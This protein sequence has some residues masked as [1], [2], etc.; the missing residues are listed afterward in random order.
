MRAKNLILYYKAFIAR[1]ILMLDCRVSKLPD[2][3]SPTNTKGPEIIKVIVAFLSISLLLFGSTLP[4]MSYSQSNVTSQG[5]GI[6][7]QLQQQQKQQLQL[8]QPQLQQQQKQELQ[9][10]MQEKGGE[11]RTEKIPNGFEVDE[12][13]SVREVQKILNQTLPSSPLKAQILGPTALGA[14]TENQALQAATENQALQVQPSINTPAP[15]T[16]LLNPTSTQPVSDTGALAR[17]CDPGLPIKPGWVTVRPYPYDNVVAEGVIGGSRIN[18]VHHDYPFNH[19]SHDNNFH[20]ILDPKYNGLA[21]KALTPIKD[22]PYI[23]RYS[24]NQEWEIGTTNDGRTDRFPK[25][26]WPWEG[27]RVWMMGKWVYDCMHFKVRKWP[28]PLFYGYNTEIHPAFATAF[29]RD[30][31]Y[32]FGGENKPSPTSYTYIWING[33]G[34]FFNTP[35]GGQNYEFDI[36][37]PQKEYVPPGSR[38][39]ADVFMSTLGPKPIVTLKPQR[40][41]FSGVMT[42]CAH[43]VIPLSG[44]PASTGLKYGA[45]I[46]TK[47]VE[48]PSTEGFRVIRVTFDS[49]RVR[50]DHDD[51]FSGEWNHLWVG[52]NGKWIELSG[53]NGHYGLDD[54][55]NGQLIR[56]PGGSKSV[57][58][59]VPEKGQLKIMTTGW[60]SDP[61]D[62]CFGKSITRLLYDYCLGP[63]SD[64]DN[65]GLIVNRYCSVGQIGCQGNFGIGPHAPYSIRNPSDGPL[66]T[67][68]DFVLNYRIEQ[69][70]VYPPAQPP[71][72]PPAPPVKPP[73]TPPP[74][75]EPL[76]P[77]CKIRPWLPQCEELM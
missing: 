15:P 27:D 73:T 26:F 22:G 72:T 56:F 75:E 11:L 38:L 5:E 16:A 34:G 30:I 44:V 32:K 68:G 57:T 1:P 48:P 21:S 59:T 17:G 54:V 51:F 77:I 71:V 50:E 45:A 4:M 23:G 39:R 19:K 2:L 69:F 3:R 9:D 37:M 49:I 31:A 61:I 47:W 12:E 40:C 41:D 53:P 14:A 28:L 33:Q 52:V 6:Q 64:N 70:F 24:M 10:V 43:V 55:D 35:V 42:P 18:V 8:Q 7:P 63:K 66:D 60:E 20:V 46:A 65:I 29:T 74:P 25:D 67:N 13:F 58:V 62:D 36:P 76:P